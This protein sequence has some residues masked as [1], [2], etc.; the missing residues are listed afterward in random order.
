MSR[1]TRKEMKR[2]EVLDWVGRTVQYVRENARLLLIIAGVI[3]TAAA[4]AGAVAAHKG[5]QADRANRLLTEALAD[6][7]AATEPAPG[8][9]VVE[10]ADS[11]KREAAAKFEAIH[12]EFAGKSFGAMAAA[13]LGDLA[14]EAGE[15]DRAEAL[16]REALEGIDDSLLAGRLQLNLIHLARAQGRGE[17]VVEELRSLLGSSDSPLPEDVV[18]YELGT[19]LDELGRES[20]AVSAYERLLEEYDSS[21]YAAEAERK[22]DES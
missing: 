20:E 15:T 2:D 7:D 22:L 21:A 17:E 16:W 8:E 13:Y 5:R 4:V 1:L 12:K 19:T 6:L 11:Q 18:L 10:D 3:V 14:A 9:V